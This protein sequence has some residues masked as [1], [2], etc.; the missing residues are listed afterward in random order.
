[1]TEFR[2]KKKKNLGYFVHHVGKLST[3]KG[4]YLPCL[5]ALEAV[6]D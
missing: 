2:K 5:V 3:G 4:D 6:P 1:M